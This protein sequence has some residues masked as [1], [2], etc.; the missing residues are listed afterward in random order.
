MEREKNREETEK[1]I[2]PNRMQFGYCKN[3]ISANVTH[4]ECT[5]HLQLF[6]IHVYVTASE[7]KQSHL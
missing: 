3:F 6:Y 5:E 4:S 1:E 7:N 2:S